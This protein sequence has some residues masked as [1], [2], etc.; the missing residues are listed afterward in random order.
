MEPVSLSIG[1]VGLIDPL[2]QLTGIVK[3]YRF[4]TPDSDA[5]NAQFEA[6]RL[7]FER[8]KR[9]V[10]SD[11]QLSADQQTRSVVEN[12]LR[13]IDNIIEAKENIHQTGKTKSRPV[14][15]AIFDTGGQHHA[16]EDAGSKRH[17]LT[18]ALGRKRDLTD[19]VTRFGKVVQQVHDLVP[20]NQGASTRLSTDN[21]SLETLQGSDLQ[22]NAPGPGKGLEHGFLVE[23][24]QIMTELRQDLEK[25]QGKCG[26]IPD[27]AQ[28]NEGW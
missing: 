13:V 14:N 17:K 10:G 24:H 20:P 15:N 11:T 27:T 3:T 8:W 1:L 6:E 19:L 5:L 23:L 12:L 2:I 22:G 25:A 21:R 18:W 26:Y 16:R 7:R 9:S 28:A 4:F